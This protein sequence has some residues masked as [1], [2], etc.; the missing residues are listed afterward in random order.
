MPRFVGRDVPLARLTDTLDHPPAVVLVEGE[1]GI[2][3]TRLVTEWLDA[4]PGRRTLLTACP[5]F[6]Q[7][8]TLGPIVDAVRRATGSVRSLRLSDLAGVLRPLFPEW[9]EHLPP[10]PE[11]LEDLTAARHRL[12]RAWLELLGAL[13][14]DT[15]I[16]EDAHWADEATLEFLLFLTARHPPAGPSLVV[17]YR[18]EDVPAGSL[19]PRLSSR[20][21]SGP[22][23][24]ALTLEPLDVA[25]TAGL[26][27]S[28][29][30]DGHISEAFAEF[31]HQ[32]TEGVPLAVEESVRLLRHRG[33]VV[34]RGDGEWARR[35]LA[36]L[37]VP[38][39]IRD[40]VL[41]RSQRL[42]P[43][44][45][46]ILDAAA[47][48]GEPVDEALLSTV[49][50]LDGQDTAD[51]FEEV[52]SLR[53]LTEGDRH[54]LAFRHALTARA[55]YDALVP[56]R[57]RHLHL[58]AGRALESAR[59]LP[60]AR[61]AR[62]FRE[63]NAVPEWIRYTEAAVDL[64]VE[65]LDVTPA[66]AALNDLL[67]EAGLEA[68]VDLAERGRLGARLATL[69]IRREQIDQ[70]HRTVI[71]TLRG[72]LDGGGIDVRHEAEIRYGLGRLLV[73]VR[74][75]DEGRAELERAADQLVH[76]PGA[77]ASIMAYLA[78]PLT[79]TWP[80]RRHRMWLH[81][82]TM[83]LPMVREQHHVIELVGMLAAA[84]LFLGDEQGWAVAATLST[85]GTT[86]RER[87]E[88]AGARSNIGAAAIVWGDYAEARRQLDLGREVSLT[89]EQGWPLM[90]ILGMRVELD[91]ISGAWPGLREKAGALAEA[92]DPDGP[93]N[94]DV[95]RVLG[96]L[97]ALDGDLDGGEAILRR[98]LDH[99]TANDQFTASI[100]LAAEVGRVRLARRDPAGAIEVTDGPMRRLEAKG[101][102]VWGTEIGPVRAQALAAA[103]EPAELARL[104][105]A[106]TDGLDG[107]PAP[108]PRAA[109][110]ACQ[111]FLSETSG[112]FALAAAGFERA[113]TA[114]GALPRPL[115]SLLAREGAGRCLI[116]AGDPGRGLA[117][118]GEVFRDL[119][120][121]GARA[122]ADR[123][124]GRLRRD[125]VE[126][127]R[128]WRGGRRGYG[129]QLS[130]REREVVR[131]VVAGHTN[132]Q[133]AA[134]LSRSPKTVS[135]QL[136]SAMR[137]LGVTS[138]TA[139]AV[140]VVQSESGLTD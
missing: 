19:L 23:R 100:A 134:A 8:H 15:L 34:R 64:A 56:T 18:P 35:S 78:W 107:C 106:F 94:L 95:A 117:V 47:V 119:T 65:A 58:R 12:F 85:E 4:H 26:V 13:N 114:F 113:V 61:L 72:I 16:V 38:A 76:E 108:A 116:A 70:R 129:D 46:R 138:R 133:I 36:E 130:P 29:F 50:G 135:S 24:A 74:A 51:A 111:A 136:N 37:Q 121:L 83:I 67:T 39:M 66:V 103:G 140:A 96:A 105:A 1:A 109:L 20:Q 2:G 22:A 9:A 124:A 127:P 90:L 62:H 92:D 43:E 75:A 118:L 137:K 3:K 54:R 81:R 86:A 5:P 80:A 21:G 30:G 31:L 125:G 45:R 49:A 131:L 110:A 69:A 40:S 59:P 53:L 97:R 139:L 73:R 126:V 101:V 93:I 79:S 77:R 60:V 99:A 48:L 98:A 27:S 14:V 42:G 115:D 33:D 84:R 25:G 88:I 123:V 71:A 132:R 41:E 11:P 7:P 63:A 82:A 104:V 128:P 55:V 91:L 57:R 17:T 87:R 28:M 102:W 68:A 44:A 6:R 89:E 52:I 10:A 122:D 32:H 112:E 120:E